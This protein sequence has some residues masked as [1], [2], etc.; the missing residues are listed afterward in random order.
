MTTAPDGRE[1]VEAEGRAEWRAWLEAH[2]GETPGVWLCSWR[3]PTGR[4]RCPYPDAVEEAICFG[5]IDSTINT[6]DEDR[7]LQLFTPRKGKSAVSLNVYGFADRIEVS[8]RA[9]GCF[10][11]IKA[12]LA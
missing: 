12:L 2:H 6:L 3:T 5:W 10:H 9:W 11:C 7:G 4:P 8:P 1:L